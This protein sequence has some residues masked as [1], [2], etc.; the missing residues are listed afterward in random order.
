CDAQKQR[1]QPAGCADGN[2][3]QEHKNLRPEDKL[4]DNRRTAKNQYGAPLSRIHVFHVF[5]R[6]CGGGRGRI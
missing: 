5:S 3:F 4:E 1:Q 6:S 2:P